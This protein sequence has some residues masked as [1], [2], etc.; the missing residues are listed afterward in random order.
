VESAGIRWAIAIV[1][2]QTIDRIGK[3][4]ANMRAM[5]MAA[6]CLVN[7]NRQSLRRLPNVSA[8]HKGS[9]VVYGANDPPQE[10]EEE[11]GRPSPK[12]RCLSHSVDRRNAS[13]NYYAL[14]DGGKNRIP[15]NMPCPA[16]GIVKGDNREY[17]I[18]AASIL[19]TVTFDRLMVEYDSLV[20]GC[21]KY[22]FAK[23]RGA[24]T[25]LHLRKIQLHGVCPIHRRSYQPMK[26]MKF[27]AEGRILDPGPMEYKQFPV[28][29]NVRVLIRWT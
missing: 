6:H 18:A 24:P 26:S 29:D 21:G 8:L 14:V 20:D 12:S 13:C 27:D 9:Y 7:P 4:R 15:R 3:F 5:E 28:K 11:E 17:V 25:S 2:P 19:A 1:D 10:E 22:G 16:E 23:H